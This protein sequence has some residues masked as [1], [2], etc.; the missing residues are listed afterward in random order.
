MTRRSESSSGKAETNESHRFSPLTGAPVV[1]E[2]NNNSMNKVKRWLKQVQHSRGAAEPERPYQGGPSNTKERV[3][4]PHS[5]P[6]RPFEAEEMEMRE[7]SPGLCVDDSPL[8]SV[9]SHISDEGVVHIEGPQP[10]VS[11]VVDHPRQTNWACSDSDQPRI[12]PFRKRSRRK[13]RQDRYDSGKD[14]SATRKSIRSD[15]KS[16]SHRKRSL[17]SG[18]EVMDNFVTDAVATQ[19]LTMKP[20]LSSGLFLNGRGAT[21]GDLKFN[22]VHILGRDWAGG[23]WEAR[24]SRPQ[25]E[26]ER[27]I[28]KDMQGDSDFFA[29]IPPRETKVLRMAGPMTKRPRSDSTVVVIGSDRADALEDD[30]TL[31][32]G[33]IEPR[34]SASKCLSLVTKGT[35]KRGL[36]CTGTPAY[37]EH[38]GLSH[39]SC[40]AHSQSQSSSSSSSDNNE[41][42]PVNSHSKITIQGE[43]DK[44]V[45]QPRAHFENQMSPNKVSQQYEQRSRYADA[46]VQT[47]TYRDTGTMVSPGSTPLYGRLVLPLASSL[48][49]LPV[50][51]ENDSLRARLAVALE[52]SHSVGPS[53]QGVYQAVPSPQGGAI[54]A[55]RC[56]KAGNEPS[57][58][59]H[60][61]Q[62]NQ[63]SPMDGDGFETRL[64]Q[65]T[66]CTDE[67]HAPTSNNMITSP[68]VSE[69]CRPFK[70]SHSGPMVQ[71]CIYGVEAL[72]ESIPPM[73]SFESGPFLGSPGSMPAPAASLHEPASTSGIP[74]ERPQS[75]G[76]LNVGDE[77]KIHDFI[78][79]VEKE[80]LESTFADSSVYLEDGAGS[81][82]QFLDR[83]TIDTQIHANRWAT[84]LE[85]I[86]DIDPFS[87]SGFAPHVREDGRHLESSTNERRRR[88]LRDK[89]PR[90]WVARGYDELEM[91]RFWRPNVYQ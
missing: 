29:N 46:G 60:A 66:S 11:D 34:Q 50:P 9:S 23:D 30:Q 36:G 74:Q 91:M 62:T 32:E 69:A 88:P 4:R 19:R 47:S 27:R 44:S 16:K 72:Q 15:N 73:A 48:S 75:A 71:P 49:D 83:D 37:R 2:T 20:N 64:V 28:E 42:K 84:D 35:M 45:T 1:R 26:D 80:M 39:R 79:R 31:R 51:R 7:R 18:R 61:G 41:I 10:T 56:F 57:E 77:E 59:G 25:T 43:V 67:N 55:T 86:A 38:P 12:D 6:V 21:L 17:R 52:P 40:A 78:A 68:L 53:R 24:K 89:L 90:S 54:E 76:L 81:P 13:T 87:H 33:A 85:D 8:P 58:P 70:F 5:L 65:R 22:G 82:V 63:A 3:W 14:K